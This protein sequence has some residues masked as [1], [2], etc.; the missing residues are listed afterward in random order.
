MAAILG[1]K[2]PLQ[3]RPL[4]TFERGMRAVE[5]LA[6]EM[7]GW[8]EL[9]QRLRVSRRARRWRAPLR[10]G[11][12]GRRWPRTWSPRRRG[13]TAVLEPVPGAVPFAGRHVSHLEPASGLAC[14]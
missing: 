8:L 12:D 5:D 6:Q 2:L 9:D 10:T 11:S 14:Y 3:V 7:T 4:L 1:E 13:R